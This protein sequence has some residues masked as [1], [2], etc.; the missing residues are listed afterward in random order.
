MNEILKRI[1]N[2]CDEIYTEIENEYKTLEECDYSY[3]IDREIENCKIAVTN[4]REIAELSN[5]RIRIAKES[6]AEDNA[7]HE[8]QE[9][10][11]R[12]QDRIDYLQEQEKETLDSLAG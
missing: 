7:K 5:V 4:L 6:I 9:G 2:F 8:A 3:G 1:L 12:E 10:Y 11:E